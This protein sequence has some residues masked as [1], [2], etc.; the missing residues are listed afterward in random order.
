MRDAFHFVH[1]LSRQI[2]E[3]KRKLKSISTY[4]ELNRDSLIEQHET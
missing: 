2:S 1:F 3:C 4:V